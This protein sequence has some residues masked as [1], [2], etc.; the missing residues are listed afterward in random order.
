[1]KNK[2]LNVEIDEYNKNYQMILV[3]FQITKLESLDKILEMFEKKLIF[4]N[5][6]ISFKK[7][8]QFEW[9]SKMSTT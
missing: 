3:Q 5:K 7:L 1:M 2:L 4:V 8:K 9:N 6:W